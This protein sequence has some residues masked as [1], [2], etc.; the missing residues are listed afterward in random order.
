MQSLTAELT[1]KAL[2]RDSKDWRLCHVCPSCTYKL[3]SEEK[4]KFSMLY[5]MDGNDSLKRIQRREA[6]PMS[7]DNNDSNGLLVLGNSSE[8]MDN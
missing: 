2:R 3:E 8:S 6:I 7:A 4:L 5:T 1:Q